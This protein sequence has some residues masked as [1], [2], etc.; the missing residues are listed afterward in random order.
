MV[1]KVLEAPQ[2]FFV[3]LSFLFCKGVCLFFLFLFIFDFFS[4]KMFISF[5]GKREKDHCCVWPFYSRPYYKG[6]G[7][8]SLVTLAI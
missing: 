8:S 2:K 1:W 5:C 4:Q 6:R 3:C 7:V